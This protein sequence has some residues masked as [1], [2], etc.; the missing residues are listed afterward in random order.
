MSLPGIDGVPKPGP[1]ED[2]EGSREAAAT[3]CAAKASYV[4]DTWMLTCEATAS[5]DFSA[6]AERLAWHAYMSN[7]NRVSGSR[8]PNE[9]FE[10][11]AE[12]EAMLRMGWS[13]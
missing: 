4:G 9:S 1:V 13:P 8:G 11:W 2:V 3:I 6:D 7:T 12:A 10:R 5:L